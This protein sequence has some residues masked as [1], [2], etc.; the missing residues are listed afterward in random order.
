MVIISTKDLRFLQDELSYEQGTLYSWRLF[1]TTVI[2]FCMVERREKGDEENL[3]LAGEMAALRY[4]LRTC[5]ED[6]AK[7][8]MELG[9]ARKEAE[10]ARAD[11]ADA[12][13][14]METTTDLPI[15]SGTCMIAMHTLYYS[16]LS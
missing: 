14:I 10:A 13:A 2:T 12:K 9:D 16:L 6:T 8:R 1:N 5:R 11:L 3:C 4:D 15:G 7:L